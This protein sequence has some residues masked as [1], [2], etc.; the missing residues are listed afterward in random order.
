MTTLT[1][2]VSS[3]LL[4]LLLLTALVALVRRT[5]RM[6]SAICLASMLLFLIVP[7]HAIELRRAEKG[8][9]NISVAQNETVD[10]TLVAFGDSV[11][12]NGVVTG[13]LITFARRINVQ[14]SVQGNLITFGQNI[15]ITGRVDGDIMGFAQTIQSSGDIGKNLWVFAQTVTMGRDGRIEQNATAFG[16]SINVDGT[17]RP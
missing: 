7:A 3:L 14:G 12:I 17:V 5:R 8:V 16:S 4:G 13:D 2:E 6:A 11:D 9:G 15:D 1:N 10:D